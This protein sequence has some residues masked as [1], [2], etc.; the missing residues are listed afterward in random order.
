MSHTLERYFNISNITYHYSKVNQLLLLG[1]RER[2]VTR[3]TVVAH[4]LKCFQFYSFYFSVKVF[5]FRDQEKKIESLL[6]GQIYLQFDEL[7]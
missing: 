7:F 6:A 2:E 3:D 1:R 5:D 4:F